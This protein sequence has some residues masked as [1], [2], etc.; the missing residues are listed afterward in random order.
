MAKKVEVVLIA[1]GGTIA[2]NF[3]TISQSIITS[4]AAKDLVLSIPELPQNVELICKQFKNVPSYAFTVKDMFDLWKNI[5]IEFERGINSIVIT[6]G[7]DTLEETA[8]F[9]SL[10]H[11]NDQALILTGS[12]REASDWSSDGPRNLYQ[13]IQVA[14]APVSAQ[15]GVLVVFNDQIF[16]GHEIIKNNTWKVDAF[17][18]EN[19]PIGEIIRN[20]VIFNRF[21]IDNILNINPT[22]VD[23]RVPIFKTWTGENDL[24]LKSWLKVGL[25]G[26]VIEGTG[27]GN[28]HPSIIPTLLLLKQQDIPI[29][30]STRVQY[31]RTMPIYGGEGGG[32]KLKEYGFLISK[33]LSSNKAR[34]KLIAL[35]GSGISKQEFAYYF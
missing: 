28:V 35:L 25:D 10:C 6:H 19:G 26:L 32:K 2:S 23:S 7:T 31:G 12:M 17:K 20:N 11:K 24:Y 1:T 29:I 9:L 30:I 5:Q 14:L 3:D 27:A 33:N 18:S 21:N 22:H 15:K 34:L 16:A 4:L 8:Y 13:S